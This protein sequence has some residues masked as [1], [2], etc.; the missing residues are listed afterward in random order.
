MHGK[1]TRK[2]CCCAAAGAVIHN[3]G[4]L[5]GLVLQVWILLLGGLC[6]LA[7]NFASLLPDLLSP[8]SSS[9]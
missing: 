4:S 1:F 6:E 7:V 9:A 3:F 2:G 8:P 5:L